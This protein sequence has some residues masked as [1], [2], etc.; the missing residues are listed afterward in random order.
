MFCRTQYT[1][2]LF[3]CIYIYLLDNFILTIWLLCP[4]SWK[5][6]G[7]DAEYTT[8]SSDTN[9]TFPFIEFI[10]DVFHMYTDWG[11]INGMWLSVSA[12]SFVSKWIR[13]GE[14]KKRKKKWIWLTLRCDKLTKRT[15]SC[16]LIGELCENQFGDQLTEWLAEVWIR[17]F[18]LEK[19]I[20]FA[21]GT[22]LECWRYVFGSKL[23]AQ[24]H[25]YHYLLL[26]HYCLHYTL[27]HLR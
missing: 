3:M 8:F 22:Y 1:R 19:E 7:H 14:K 27:P 20:A 17:F 15:V 12:H 21:L 18:F 24:T 6:N 16:R 13:L 25:Y 26:R 9:A 5:I 23:S 11:S 4:W 2:H 10:N